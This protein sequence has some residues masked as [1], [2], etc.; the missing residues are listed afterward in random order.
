VVVDADGLYHLA[1]GLKNK[2]ELPKNVNWILTPHLGELKQLLVHLPPQW[3]KDWE[4]SPL[5]CIEKLAQHLGVHIV[6]KNAGATAIVSP[7]KKIKF[8]YAPCAALATAGSGDILA[9]MICAQLSLRR[10]ECVSNNQLMVEI[11]SAC[12]F[13]HNQLGQS[14][15]GQGQGALAILE[16]LEKST[17]SE[18][19]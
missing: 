4:L 15:L 2:L 9:G 1:N 14:I 13:L 10:E 12:V 17:F 3:S 16:K 6:L 18:Q 5:G 7:L 19:K 11:L 8:H